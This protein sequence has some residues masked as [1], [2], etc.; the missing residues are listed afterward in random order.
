[1]K[2]ASASLIF[3]PEIPV[4]M[5]GYEKRR[6]LSTG[7]HQDLKASILLL[8][9]VERSVIISFDLCGIDQD[10]IERIAHFSGYQPEQLF[11]CAT[12]THAS[13][14]EF[15]LLLSFG[16]LTI[17]EPDETIR[18]QLA[19]QIADVLK[20]TEADLE[21]VVIYSKVTQAV[22][23][24]ANRNDCEGPVDRFL[25]TIIFQTQDGKNK[26]C[27]VHMNTHPTILDYHNTLLSPDF[28][29]TMRCLVET[30]LNC[31]LTVINGACADV[32][33]RFTRR[34]SSIAECERVGHELY[35][36]IS[37]MN[38][39]KKI[40]GRVK[41]HMMIYHAK[42]CRYMPELEMKLSILELGDLLLFGF[43][44]EISVRFSREIKQLFDE[45]RV[46]I[47]GYTNDYL[48]YFIDNKDPKD[49]YEANICTLMP[50]ESIDFVDWLKSTLTF[51]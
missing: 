29:G 47:C 9:D 23:L 13:I 45:Q 32:S 40:S 6:T 12:H 4:F 49:T 28:I 51:L 42:T 18:N 24:F 14:N 11:V 7:V 30:Q 33:T 37:D 43:P 48:G 34:E 35:K 5:N 36:K 22:G 31:P 39:L 50:E 1:M 16:Q 25:N 15:P 46:L 44:G 41:L 2:A 3:T 26:G 38:G 27:I 19:Q 17:R 21:E 10:L 20:Q 8:E